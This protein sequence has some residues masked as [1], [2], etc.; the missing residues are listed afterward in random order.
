MEAY[1]ARLFPALRAM[2]IAVIVLLRENTLARHFASSSTLAAGPG[3]RGSRN[4]S[5][6]MDLLRQL[7]HDRSAQTSCVSA[8]HTRLVHAG[9]PSL[10]VRYE[11]LNQR[12]SSF[13][14]VF[15]FLDVPTTVRWNESE[16]TTTLVGDNWTYTPS[17]ATKH[18]RGGPGA[19]LSAAD[20]QTAAAFLATNASG[21]RLCD[22][23]DTC[24]T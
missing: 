14:R 17:Q 11:E 9:I 20:R 22:L 7:D 1:E 18:H 8:V 4:K 5:V 16:A 3:H 19:F 23:S 6:D 12:H 15:R 21:L 13:Q 10:M 24:Y 2:R